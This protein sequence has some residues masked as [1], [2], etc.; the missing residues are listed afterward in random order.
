MHDVFVDQ[1]GADL[2]N[3]VA[4]GLLQ[5]EQMFRADVLYAWWLLLRYSVLSSAVAERR[6]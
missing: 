4:H 6:S 1:L 2:R 5:D 3:E